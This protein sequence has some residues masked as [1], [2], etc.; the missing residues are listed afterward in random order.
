MTSEYPR[1]QLNRGLV[2]LRYKQ[3]YIDWVRTAGELPMDLTLENA[4]DDSEAFLVPSFDSPIDPVDGTEDAIKWV[5]KRWRMFFE[6]IL[7][8]WI[9][10][11]AEWPKKR[12]LKMFREWFDVEYKSMVWDMGNEPLIFEEWDDEDEFD[13]GSLLH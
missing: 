11:E 9:L 5:E 13:D 7:S 10:D 6:H 12:T 2:V 1:F 4:N 8:S 3:P